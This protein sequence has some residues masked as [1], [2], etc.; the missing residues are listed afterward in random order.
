LKTIT[1]RLRPGYLRKNGVPYSAKAVVTEYYN[2]VS[3]PNG[4]VWLIVNTHVDDP[5]FLAQPFVTSSQF[6]KLPNGSQ[7]KPVECSAS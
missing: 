2:V 1:T 6:R 5:E 3:E 4:G 7:W